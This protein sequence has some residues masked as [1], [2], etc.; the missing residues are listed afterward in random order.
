MAGDSTA[1]P[2]AKVTASTFGSST[3]SVAAA[4]EQAADGLERRGHHVHQ[5]VLDRSPDGVAQAERGILDGAGDG[6]G[7]ADVPF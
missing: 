1:L 7:R 3:L 4:G 2:A 6:N 5:D